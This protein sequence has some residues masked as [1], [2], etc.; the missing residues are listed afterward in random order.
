MTVLVLLCLPLAFACG[1]VLGWRLRQGEVRD[2]YLRGIVEGRSDALGLKQV[3]A[4]M[5]RIM[6]AVRPAEAQR[7]AARRA[8]D[9]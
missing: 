5:Q 7:E 2:A 4:A 1:A 6:L 8:R 9:N 3:A